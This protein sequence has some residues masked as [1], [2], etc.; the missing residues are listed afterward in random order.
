[1]LP[2]IV[3]QH[4]FVFREWL[5]IANSQP[6]NQPTNSTWNSIRFRVFL[7]VTLCDLEK[8]T[9]SFH[10]SPPSNKCKSTQICSAQLQL[11][12]SFEVESSPSI[13]FSIWGICFPLS[14]TDRIAWWI[15]DWSELNFKSCGPPRQLITAA[16]HCPETKELIS[17]PT[18][19]SANRFIF[20]WLMNSMFCSQSDLHSFVLARSC[21]TSKSIKKLP[22]AICLMQ[23]A[24]APHQPPSI[25][26]RRRRRRL[27]MKLDSPRN[28]NRAG[29]TELKTKEKAA[30]TLI[31]QETWL[32]W[33]SS[34]FWQKSTNCL[35]CLLNDYGKELK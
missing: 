14:L 16:A 21:F 4:F 34:P 23:T 24:S 15:T 6:A 26:R 12:L 30:G 13:S 7:S 28:W 3:N 10:A 29:R 25:R 5:A 1:M 8:K 33:C 18:V 22:C 27:N 20:S 11:H 35:P 17:A 32:E 9:R 31:W 2:R 19:D